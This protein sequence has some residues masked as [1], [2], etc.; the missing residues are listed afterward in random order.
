MSNG[1]K[2]RMMANM[3]SVLSTPLVRVYLQ[4]ACSRVLISPYAILGIFRENKSQNG[5]CYAPKAATMLC[6]IT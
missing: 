2:C 1:E 3:Q 6:Q 5:Y 4:C